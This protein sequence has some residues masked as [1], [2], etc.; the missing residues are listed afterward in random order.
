MSLLG[1]VWFV[2]ET[3]VGRTY[4]AVGGCTTRRDH[5]WV[6]PVVMSIEYIHSLHG[7]SVNQICSTCVLFL[8]YIYRQMTATANNRVLDLT[9]RPGILA[10]G[11]LATGLWTICGVVRAK[12]LR[13]IYYCQIVGLLGHA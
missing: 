1:L 3:S 5:Y 12:F 2:G 9:A 7:V 6:A 11:G 13:V 8:W 10:A 4:F